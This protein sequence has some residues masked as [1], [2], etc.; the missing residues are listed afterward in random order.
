MVCF[1]SKEKAG[2]GDAGQ[3]VP[4]TL[5]PGPPEFRLEP[6]EHEDWTWE[7][8]GRGERAVMGRE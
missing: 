8:P 2:G 4:V 5:S 6:A 1:M 7:A 3:G